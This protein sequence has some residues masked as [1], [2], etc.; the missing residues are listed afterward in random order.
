MKRIAL[1]VVLLFAIG[2]SARAIA[3]TGSALAELNAESPRGGSTPAES[4]RLT[5]VDVVRQDRVILDTVTVGLVFVYEPT[6]DV[7]NL[8]INAWLDLAAE[9]QRRAVP[10][11]GVGVAD[12]ARA[13]A[14]WGSLASLMTLV[15]SDTADVVEGLGATGT[16]TT[17]LIGRGVRLQTHTGPISRGRIAA[18]TVAM[19]SL[20]AVR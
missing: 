19:D 4:F 1:I 8:N 17:V 6:C 14:Y 2:A 7:C 13:V 5:G 18:L 12:S 10:L 3:R 9:A 20:I 15:Q 16:P 11:F